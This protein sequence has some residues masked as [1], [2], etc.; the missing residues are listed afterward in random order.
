MLTEMQSRQDLK[1][2]K[3]EYLDI[4]SVEMLQAHVRTLLVSNVVLICIYFYTTF[5]M[6]VTQQKAVLD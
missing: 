6:Q 2:C 4:P 5:F 1:K 3:W